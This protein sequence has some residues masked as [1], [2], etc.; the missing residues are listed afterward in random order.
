MEI[1]ED[2]NQTWRQ[3]CECT[4]EGGG[5]CERHKITKSRR[6]VE[7]CNENERYWQAWEKGRGPKQEHNAIQPKRIT[8]RP[9]PKITS[10]RITKRPKISSTRITRHPKISSP[11]HPVLLGDRVEQALSALGITKD[12]VEQWL[13]RP[14]GC[15]RRQEKLNQLDR[16]A[17]RIIG[18]KTEKAQE[19]LEGIINE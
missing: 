4:I 12:R 10:P 19:Y 3:L 16:W 5:W 18:G 2:T 17:R 8:K 11:Q 13:G 9:K 6:L 1:Q 14:C 15:A 7:L